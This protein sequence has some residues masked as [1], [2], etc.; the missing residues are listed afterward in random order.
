M[1]KKTLLAAALALPLAAFAT[2]AIYNGTTAFNQISLGGGGAIVTV[3]DSNSDGLLGIGDAFTESGLIAGLAFL[4]GSANPIASTGLGTSYELWAKFEPMSGY[5]SAATI[6]SV[7]NVTLTGY[8]VRFVDPSVVRIFRDTT[9]GGGFN[10]ATSTMV[11]VA[12]SPASLSNCT[13]ERI[14]SPNAAVNHG[15]C[16][17]DF[18]FDRLGP[19]VAGMWTNSYGEDFGNIAHGGLHIDLN[20]NRFTPWFSPVFDSTGI[21]TINIEHTGT[22]YFV[23]EPASLALMGIA[24]LG[25]GAIRR[26]K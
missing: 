26:R 11:G 6:G 3:I 21:Q 8:A 13:V 20:V 4:D 24:L 10:E 22:G 7:G 18:R 17:L 14:A 16:S 9:V 15:S 1:F 5:V 19:T 25:F 23:P 2:P 12:D